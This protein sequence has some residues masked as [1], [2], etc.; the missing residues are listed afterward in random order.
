M[1]S[2]ILAVTGGTLGI[3][4]A[5]WGLNALLAAAPV[6]LPRLNEVRLDWRVLLFALSISALAG[7]VFGLLPAVRSAIASPIE[8]LKSGSRSNTEGRGGLRV[9]NLLVS[10][11]VGL[12]AA[13]LVTA[14]LLIASFMRVMNV[15]PG[16]QVER[17]LAVHV[18]LLQ[19]KY[20]KQTDQAAF[21]ARLL[22]KAAAIPGVQSTSLVSTI[23]LSGEAWI[24][25]I[26]KEHDTRPMTELPTANVR[27][28]SPE[29]F[30]TLRAKLRDGRSFED[31]DRKEKVAI[32]SAS[33]AQRLWGSEN[34]V[35]RKLT[36]ND[37][38]MEVVGVA[39]DIHST[40]LDHDPVNILYEPYWQRP[41]TG[42]SLLM[43]TAMDPRR[44]VNTVRAA[45]WELDS[46]ATIP[47]VRTLEEVMSN[48]VAQR[49]FQVVLVLLF[50][51]AAISLAAIGTY[52]VLSYAVTRRTSEMGIRMALGARQSDVLRMVLRQGMMPVIV[53]LASGAV[54]ALGVGR[55]I[56]SLL[57]QVSP[58]DP[59]AFAVSSAL[60]LMVSV[61]ACLIPARRATR[62]NPIDAL[63][64][65]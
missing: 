26:A 38:V 1:E 22:D 33:L 53:G 7:V 8:T 34:P 19:S 9:R 4:L 64:F 13:L 25:L 52:G 35:G 12:S 46:E 65:E 57:Y 6:D 30:Q 21:F 32:V 55:Y 54:V 42:S 40:S 63:R 56:E 27:V 49:R 36:D 29:Y 60:L 62:V 45:I 5:W 10:I 59:I 58:R 41:S 2:L 44:I 14:G 50:A 11:E 43:R 3:L 17:V 18:S 23:P 15:N 16:F 31:R 48:S 24:D 39:S 47:N 37:R 61:A 51:L 28:I 20:G